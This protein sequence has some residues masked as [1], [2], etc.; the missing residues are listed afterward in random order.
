MQ[1]SAG[2]RHTMFVDHQF[3]SLRHASLFGEP[4]LRSCLD[5]RHYVILDEI[6]SPVKDIAHPMSRLTILIRTALLVLGIVALKLIFHHFRLEIISLNPLFSSIIAGAIFIIGMILTGTLSDYKENEKVPT[7]MVNALETIFDEGKQV[8]RRWPS[9]DLERLRGAL[10]GI[11]HAFQYDLEDSSRRTS[12]SA[13]NR[14]GDSFAEMEV[15]GLAP[16]YI[17]RLKGEQSHIRRLILRVYHVQRTGFLPS[18]YILVDSMIALTTLLL[19][20]SKIEPLFDAVLVLAFISYLLIYL[21][22]LLRT[23]DTPFH[24]HKNTMDDVSRFLLKEC[25]LRL[26]EHAAVMTKAE[27]G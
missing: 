3:V 4:R 24:I 11:I 12:L 22:T 26:A 17:I 27:S 19:L 18:A 23:I 9:F 5:E 7:E 15:L 14:L 16:N 10:R 13:V 2:A 21:I 20:L 6:I 25:D 8:A 1:V